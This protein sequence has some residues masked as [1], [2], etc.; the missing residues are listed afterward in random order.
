MT[1]RELLETA[2]LVIFFALVAVVLYWA[3]SISKANE[4]A[5]HRTARDRAIAA[6]TKGASVVTVAVMPSPTISRRYRVIFSGS[7]YGF[8]YIADALEFVESVSRGKRA[9]AHDFGGVLLDHPS[10][11]CPGGSF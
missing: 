8:E 5:R 6:M 1:D 2:L 4:R 9:R 7:L 10:M 11:S 3:Y